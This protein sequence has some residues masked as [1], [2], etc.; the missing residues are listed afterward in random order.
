MGKVTITIRDDG[1][2]DEGRDLMDVKMEFDPPLSD[3]SEPSA[4]Q[5]FGIAML[6]SA[7][8]ATEA[9]LEG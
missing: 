2:S 6:E 4:A 5:A 8:D 7:A 9:R 3:D 1:E